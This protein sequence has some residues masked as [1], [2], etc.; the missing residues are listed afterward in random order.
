MRR[1]R[2]HVPPLG[3]QVQ[4]V[5]ITACD[6]PERVAQVYALLLERRARPVSCGDTADSRADNTRQEHADAHPPAGP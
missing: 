1:A 2:S 4:S 3:W 5:A 6:G